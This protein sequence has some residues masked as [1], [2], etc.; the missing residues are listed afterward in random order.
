MEIK[1]ENLNCKKE[2]VNESKGLIQQIEESN[3]YELS[4]P[5]E[6]DFIE[7]FKKGEKQRIAFVKRIE[8]L[9]KEWKN[10]WDNKR[11]QYPDEEPP[12]WLVLKTNPNF[13]LGNNGLWMTGTETLEKY[14]KWLQ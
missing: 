4:I 10:H 8:K 2:V 9:E 5:T 11:K 6:K 1:D 3:V 12:L 14:K 13:N 7:F